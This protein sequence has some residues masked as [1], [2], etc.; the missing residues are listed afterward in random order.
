[1]SVSSPFFQGHQAFVLGPILTRHDLIFIELITSAETLFPNRSYFEVP[2]RHE[3]GEQEDAIEPIQHPLLVGDFSSSAEGLRGG[4]D[5]T[6]FP[7]TKPSAST[8]S[9]ESWLQ[10]GPTPPTSLGIV[11]QTKG[12][13]DFHRQG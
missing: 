8:F 3:F 9:L 7:E 1:M 2:G 6:G 5:T 13:V 10:L 11:S 12:K 4:D